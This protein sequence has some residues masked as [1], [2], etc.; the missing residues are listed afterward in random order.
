[1]STIRDSITD[2][3]DC[4]QSNVGCNGVTA[5]PSDLC[6]V[7]ACLCVWC[8][9]VFL[10]VRVRLFVYLCVRACDCVSVWCVCLSISVNQSAAVSTV[11]GLPSACN[12][13][14]NE[15]MLCLYMWG[16]GGAATLTLNVA[17]WWTGLVSLTPRWIYSW[18]R[19]KFPP[20]PYSS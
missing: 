9:C 14:T 10:C 15:V 19:I 1:V 2:V 11:C 3:W 12:C 20:Y 6:G 17:T 16:R 8:V 7:C 18:D 13:Y 5:T 4:C